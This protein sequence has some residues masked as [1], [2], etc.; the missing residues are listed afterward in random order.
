[1]SKSIEAQLKKLFSELHSDRKAIEKDLDNIVQ[2]NAFEGNKIAKQ[3]APKAFGKLAQSIGIEKEFLSAKVIA[4]ADY[5]PY[6]EFGTGGK[7][8]VPREWA[9]MA[10]E[11]R[12]NVRG[13]GFAEGLQSIKDWCRLKG[14]DEA[15]AYPIFITILNG[16]PEKGIKS[17]N[18]PQPFMYPAWKKTKLQFELDIRK[19]VSS[20]SR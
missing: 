3:K 9:K 15:A 7:V 13:G 5:A 12:R 1:M 4:N 11:L 6:V 8:D 16:N 18:R 19:Y 2:G 10:A 17:G 20:Q 14:I